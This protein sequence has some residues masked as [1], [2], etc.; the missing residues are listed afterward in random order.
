MFTKTIAGAALTNE[1]LNNA[2]PAHCGHIR[3][4]IGRMQKG[5]EEV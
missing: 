2:L 5:Q 3:H 4:T 1:S